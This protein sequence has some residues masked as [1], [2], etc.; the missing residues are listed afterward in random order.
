MST[1][2]N[3]NNLATAAAELVLRELNEIETRDIFGG[4]GQ[5]WVKVGPI[6]PVP[7]VIPEQMK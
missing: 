5:G 6:T 1:E 3:L 2:K 4:S 7:P